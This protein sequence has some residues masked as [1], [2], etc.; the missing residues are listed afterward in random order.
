MSSAD[1]KAAVQ[2]AFDE[3]LQFAYRKRHWWAT[4]ERLGAKPYIAGAVRRALIAAPGTDVDHVVT[5]KGGKVDDYI[6]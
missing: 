4:P 3:P 2:A 6:A 5:V 1:A